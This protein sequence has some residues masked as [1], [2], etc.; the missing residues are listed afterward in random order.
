MKVYLV[1]NE[2]YDYCENVHGS[3]LLGIYATPESA[4]I[5]RNNFIKQEVTNI[6][7]FGGYVERS[8]DYNNNP[9][10]T[11]RDDNREIIDNIFTIE[12]WSVE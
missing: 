10:V 2:F 4:E 7:N 8:E 1:H 5:A 3:L 6:T 9:V 12:E 11:H